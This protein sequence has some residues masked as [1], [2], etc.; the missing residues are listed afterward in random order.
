MREQFVAAVDLL[1][2]DAGRNDGTTVKAWS[3][4]EDFVRARV[5]G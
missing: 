3:R 2:V 4:N 5:E 1:N